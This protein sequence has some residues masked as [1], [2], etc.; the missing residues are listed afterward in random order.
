[1]V[2]VFINRRTIQ[3]I[4][5][6]FICTICC[7]VTAVAQKTDKVYLKNGDILTGEIKNLNLAILTF[8]MTG[9]GVISIKWEEVNHLQS[10]KLFILKFR[11]GTIITD[12]LD[13]SFYKKSSVQL[14]DIIEIDPIH[15]KFIQRL[16]GNV[17]VGLNYSKSSAYLQLNSAASISYRI[18]K[19][20]F[21]ALTSF[22][23][24][25]KYGDSALS[26]I[27]SF[28]LNTLL[29]LPKFYFAF[30][31]IGWQ[32]N[33]ELGLAN[34]FLYNG[35][36]GRSLIVN[37]HNRLRVSSGVSLNLEKSIDGGIYSSNFDLLESVDYKL[38]YN[39]SPKK[40]LNATY[41]IFPSISDWGRLRM[42]FDLSTKIEVIDDFFV[43]LVFYYN[44]DSKP[45]EGAS[46]NYDYGFNF[47]LS[48]KFGD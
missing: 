1:M 15:I 37:N 42:A 35:G 22:N 4:F 13:S 10:D 46:S 33:T 14:D 21:N 24:T 19:W 2:N 40:T 7:S 9:P 18:P 47:T 23:T 17:D 8:N 6:V 41:A 11:N 27:G 5:L 16:Y 20:E 39:S 48:Y 29:L 3:G 44:Y 43:G 45:L 32:K 34:R 38:F 26:K 36:I 31:Q 30:S 12:R 25:N 28:S